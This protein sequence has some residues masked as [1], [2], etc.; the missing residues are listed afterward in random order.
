LE[1][2]VSRGVVC[3]PAQREEIT[4]ERKVSIE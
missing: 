4:V 2:R 3:F 1:M